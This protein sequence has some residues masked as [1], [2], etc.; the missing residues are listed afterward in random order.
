MAEYAQISLFDV[1]Q[2][3]YYLYRVLLRDAVICKL[4]QSERGREYLDRCWL[5]EQTKPDRVKLREK[6]GGGGKH[7]GE[8]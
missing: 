5:L 8:E 3:S 2:M 6:T 4:S 7:G 1:E